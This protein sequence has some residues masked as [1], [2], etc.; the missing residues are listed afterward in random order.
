MVIKLVNMRKNALLAHKKNCLTSL[1]TPPHT[2]LSLDIL[3]FFNPFFSSTSV[4]RK[5]NYEISFFYQKSERRD[6]P[7][8]LKTTGKSSLYNNYWLRIFSR[9]NLAIEQVNYVSLSALVGLGF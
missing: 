4:I 8:R 7:W 6:E 1:P 2:S 9:L 3:K 5:I